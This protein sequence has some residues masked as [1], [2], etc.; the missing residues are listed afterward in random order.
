METLAAIFSG[1][2]LTIGGWFSPQ[3][4]PTLGTFGDPFLSIQVGTTPANGE[5]LTTDGTN[6]VWD[7]CAASAGDITSGSSTGT[8]INIYDSEL[9]GILRFNSLSAGSNITLSTTTNSNTIV[10]SAGG[11]SGTVSTSTNETAGR[12]P[13]WT[14]TSGTPAKLGEIATS[15]ITI[16]APLTSAGTPGV[17]LGGSSWVID[18]DD[19]KAADLDLTDITLNDFTN[20]AN[21]I[22]L[23]SLSAT[24]P[25]R[26]TAGVFDFTGLATTSQPASSNL[27][28][29]NGGAGVYGVGTTTVSCTD[30]VS[31]TSFSALGAASSITSTL[32]TSVD[33]SGETNLAATW[34]VIL[35]GD[36]LSF[37]GLSTST[38]AVVGNIPYFSGVNTFANVA[39]GTISAG[40][41]IS[42]DNGTRSA[43]G[44]ALAI[45]NSSPL[46]G[47]SA[48]YPFSFSNPT[49]TWLGLGT[50]TNSGMTA[51]NLYVG[52]GGIF[53]TAASSSIFGY[54]PADSATTITV[55]SGNGTIV[56]SA[57]AQDLS[58]NRTWT[59]TYTGLAT[60]SAP[61]A[62]NIFYSNGTN[63]LIPIAT[64]S[65]NVGTASALFA[66]GSNCAAGFF[67][68]GV[69]ASGAI[70]NCTYAVAT[71]TPW[72]T[73]QIVYLNN[74]GK[75]V[76]T[77]SSTLFS[78]T[79]AGYVWS[80]QNGAWGAFATSSSAVAGGNIA[81]GTPSGTINGTNK[82]FTAANTP[83]LVLLN[84]AY[85]MAPAD[86]TYTG[87]TISFVNA[88]PSG[89]NLEY[90]YNTNAST[91]SGS[92]G[93]NRVAWWDTSTTLSNDADLTFD[94]TTFFAT[95]ATSSQLTVTGA[96]DLDT[97]TSALLLTGAGG[98]VAEYAGAAA[99][100]NQFVT[101]ISALGATTC[102][103]IND[104]QWS[105][106][107][108]TVENG[109]TEASSL[110]DN[111]VLVGSGVDA[112]TAL[113][114]GTNGQLLVGSTG[115]DPVF[116][117]ANCGT[118]L[119][120][121]LGAGTFQIDVDDSYL[122][123]NGDLGTGIYDFGGATSL[124]IP[125]GTAPV[126]AQIGDWSFDTTDFQLLIAT[127]TANT[128]RVIP[129][130]IKL[131][132]ATV[133]STSPDF[134]SGGRIWIPPQR[135]G[136]TVREFH[137]AVDGGTSVVFNLSNSGGTTDSE[138]ITCDADGATDTSVDTNN[139]YVAGSLN[140]IE[141]GAIVG[142]PDYLTFAIYG[143]FSRE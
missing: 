116:A 34:P 15:S 35:S 115:A 78:P 18:I 36:T 60:T 1:L 53:Q 84:G 32:G 90:A 114:V 92:G 120:C 27:L 136:F 140:S 28:V 118:G 51:G 96:V 104:G 132:G 137:C 122:L 61:T 83:V 143:V 64:S 66:N 57:G 69:D 5:C 63:G 87:G 2:L 40:T 82:D 125:N 13:Y 24:A 131:W 94:G 11:G 38:A 127:T 43:I 73:N 70:E 7:S 41:G 4:E 119:T 124:E 52:S 91:L 102:A 10:I 74:E 19:I 135:D 106:T 126:L 37:G 129:T 16:N 93:T 6:S 101:A 76:T 67:P 9:T 3:P 95:Y 103:S 81:T 108:L 42:L 14:T 141:V 21:F 121:T 105:G 130:M 48:G 117:T 20:D 25:I 99:C 109:G 89:S 68:L 88:P 47:L 142:A 110:T 45:T 77:A 22:T 8:G 133:A 55:A 71:T 54:T 29:S 112:I 123:N 30:G 12:V 62:G 46:S 58:A 86:Y 134:I 113:T 85:Q 56:S 79:T 65:I 72:A 111:G 59:L 23:G 75:L 44:G 107:D 31:C 17:V 50:T 100:T 138:T 49:L 97:Y 80:Y 39:T 26:Y 33:I 139:T 128:P 98:D